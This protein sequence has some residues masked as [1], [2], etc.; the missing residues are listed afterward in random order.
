MALQSAAST[1]EFE[2][3]FSSPADPQMSLVVALFYANFSGAT[4]DAAKE[5]L[6]ALAED[7]ESQAIFATVDARKADDLTKH[8]KVSQLPSVLI[9]NRATKSLV[10]RLVAPSGEALVDAVECVLY[11]EHTSLEGV[12]S[13]EEIISLA[14]IPQ[15]SHSDAQSELNEKLRKLVNQSELMVFIKG[16]PDAVQCGFSRQMVAL[17]ASRNYDYGHF[18]ILS[19]ET[20]RQGLKTY[21]DW[22]T[23]P[24]VYFKGE[25]LGGLDIIKEMIS[26]GELDEMKPPIK[27]SQVWKDKLAALIASH[28]IM[29]FMKG[30]QTAPRCKFS[31]A[32]VALMTEEGFETGSYGS[33]DI[34]R[35]QDVRSFIKIYSEWPTFPQL[36][37]KSTLLGGLD[38]IKELIAAGEFQEILCG[39]H[40][41]YQ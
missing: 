38:V 13:G 22:P 36:Y 33:F 26:S 4:G 20:V 35:D 34:L 24:Q 1:P 29:V 21:S 25:L 19:D 9:L 17:L 15:S 8:F 6:S 3:L 14:D 40:A 39:Q 5:T 10:K 31:K 18:N 7:Y 30:D 32:F 16:T 12:K 11:D 41:D 27:L 2:S 28:D 37:Y 23:F